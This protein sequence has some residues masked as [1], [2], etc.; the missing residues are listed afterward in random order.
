MAR[1]LHQAPEGVQTDAINLWHDALWRGLSEQAIAV[2]LQLRLSSIDNIRRRANWVLG[3][4]YASQ[5][6][7]QLALDFFYEITRIERY[8]EAKVLVAIALC[9]QA[10]GRPQVIHSLL[11]NN[12]FATLPRHELAMLKAN[13][14]GDDER[15]KDERLRII[16]TMFREFDLMEVKLRDSEQPLSLQ[17]L[18]GK[19]VTS[20]DQPR[21]LINRPD[22]PLV[23]VIVPCFNVE[24]YLPPVVRSL[25]QQ[26]W[27]NVEILLVDDASQDATVAVAHELAKVHPCVTVVCSER[28]Q[29]AYPTRNL[30]MAHASGDFVTVH[31]A[32]DW[33]H[34][35]K[36]ER[37]IQVLLADTNLAATVSSWVRVSP[38]VNFLGLW[39]VGGRFVER[40]HSSALIR[41]SVL[42]DVGLWDEV[43]VS[44]DSEFLWRLQRHFGE[45]AVQHIDVDV[46]LSFSLVH[47]ES[48]TQQGATHVRTIYFGARRLYR[49]ASDWWHRQ[50]EQGMAVQVGQGQ[51]AFPAP[52]GVL[53]SVDD[54][55]ESIFAFDATA[56][57]PR[58]KAQLQLLK[59]KYLNLGRRPALLHWPLTPEAALEPIA[60][61]VFAF[62]QNHHLSFAHVGLKL[63]KADVVIAEHQLLKLIP[64]G[65]PQ[66][67]QL[68]DCA[69]LDLQP[70][71]QELVLASV[72]LLFSARERS[73]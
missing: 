25:V 59:A 2:L 58:L 44:A 14:F 69:V 10:L 67:H 16:N 62:M 35:Q 37:Q 72:R 9:E 73:I 13:S 15:Q 21:D 39:M 26:T 60:D 49:E 30:G 29:G 56:Q 28:N 52:L 50:V 61:D 38:T 33:S 48:L 63:A 23:S 34:P 47:Q 36:I 17:N 40:N 54:E 53:K 3:R 27:P 57:N 4:W 8:P 32:D 22:L 12:R 55:P 31:D 68:G 6:Q 42:P 41:R 65:L 20:A 24:S 51:R 66:V 64:D 19:E 18:E 11:A 46:P 45:A 7:F 5:G 71:D 43:R 70:H 1:E